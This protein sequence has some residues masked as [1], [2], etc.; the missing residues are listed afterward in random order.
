MN[1]G[2]AFK[3]KRTRAG[4]EKE[5]CGGAAGTLGEA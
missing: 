3:D 1:D 5:N 2:V 4:D